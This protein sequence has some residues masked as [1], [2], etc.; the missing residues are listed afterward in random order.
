MGTLCPHCG[1][2]NMAG[3]TICKR[4]REPLR[5]NLDASPEHDRAAPA[6]VVLRRATRPFLAL[7][8]SKREPWEWQDV[9]RFWLAW[10]LAT[11]LSSAALGMAQQVAVC[12]NF[13]L[14]LG[15]SLALLGGGVLLGSAQWLVLRRFA[16]H[17]RAWVVVSILGWGLAWS[18]ALTVAG[19]LVEWLSAE[20][21]LFDQ[22]PSAMTLL[23]AG[24]V[25]L[26]VLGCAQWFALRRF[27]G[28]AWLVPAGLLSLLAV[29]PALAAAHDPLAALRAGHCG[30]GG[31]FEGGAADGIA[32]I[33]AAQVGAIVGAAIGLVVGALTGVVLLAVFRPDSKVRW[34]G[35]VYLHRLLPI[36]LA[37]G[38]VGLSLVAWYPQ[39]S[40]KVQS[41]SCWYIGPVNAHGLG[42]IFG[43]PRPPDRPGD[44]FYQPRDLHCFGLTTEN[45][46]GG[47]R[48]VGGAYQ[49]GWVQE[50]YVQIGGAEPNTP[51]PTEAPPQAELRRIERG[52]GPVASF[53]VSPDGRQ[54]LTA[55]DGV[56][57]WAID[58]LHLLRRFTAKAE[59]FTPVAI[60]PDGRSCFYA[61][62]R[63]LRQADCAT[64]AAVH[65]FK[66]HTEFISVIAI[67]PDGRQ[68]LTSAIDKTVR[69]WDIASGKEL[70]QLRG[71][72]D[73]VQSIVFSGDGR[74][75]F[76]GRVDGGI[77]LWDLASGEELRSF[78]LQQRINSI[79]LS[80]DGRSILAGSPD[81]SLRLWDIESGSEI[82][83]FEGHT[84]IVA[85][86]AFSTDG[87]TAISGSWDQ[88]VRVWDVAS[89]RELQRFVGHRDEVTSVAFGADEY[90]VISGSLDRT[91][92]IWKLN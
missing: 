35:W 28:A 2:E 30:F 18:I 36:P 77:W 62:E 21:E 59:I 29:T 24:L 74:T 51:N 20:R 41:T 64:G 4:C 9:A 43:Q 11:G 83:R 26:L 12:D 92:R 82:R 37:L 19:H 10:V 63:V 23:P 31:F 69:L 80:P 13:L 49:S 5:A 72:T 22:L 87:R 56:Q 73:T 68:A 3:Q 50:A 91:V 61:E 85:S 71:H 48:W 7:D 47:W 76:M 81:G 25:L 79:A 89:G 60:S 52:L 66:G 45:Q 84:S 38:L 27:S 58:D 86:V 8:A 1:L 6:M 44:G 17:S 15:S 54:I 78:D 32:I 75:A 46:Y 34:R 42:L 33:T 90:M 39:V 55:S 67:S 88:T 70:R 14:S 53:A 65:S 40:G 57:L 16:Q